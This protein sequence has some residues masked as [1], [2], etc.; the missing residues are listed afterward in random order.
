MEGKKREGKKAL[1]AHKLI[2]KGPFTLRIEHY[3]PEKK[4]VEFTL[5]KR[6]KDKMEIRCP[7][8]STCL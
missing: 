6:N 5:K 7:R 4:G 2:K 3:I 1:L 8:D